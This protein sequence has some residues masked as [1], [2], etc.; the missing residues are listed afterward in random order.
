MKS[1]L[2]KKGDSVTLNSGVTEIMDDDVLQ[3]WFRSENTLIAE[4]NKRVNNI[5]VYD[6]VLDGRFKDRL[7]LDNQTGSLTITNIRNTNFEVYELYSNYIKAIML[8]LN[9]HSELNMNYIFFCLK[10]H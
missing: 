5:A 3:W 1:V 9:V 4:I 8:F 10:M 2:V 7:K 6:D